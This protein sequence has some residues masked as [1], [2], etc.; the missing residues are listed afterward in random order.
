MARK[1]IEKDGKRYAWMEFED[2]PENK[3]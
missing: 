3:T 2:P 1:I